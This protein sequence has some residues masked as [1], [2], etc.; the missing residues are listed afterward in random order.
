VTAPA[1]PAPAAGTPPR[2]RWPWVLLV[3]GVLAAAL[4]VAIWHAITDGGS[5]PLGIVIDGERV[6]DSVDL[7]SLAVHEQLLLALAATFVVLVVLLV[8]PV[9]LL[10]ALAG[11]LVAVALPLLVVLAALAILLSPLILLGWLL[12]RALRPSPSIE[13]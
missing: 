7:G 9:A 5:L 10:V 2:R 12:W 8:V 3:A 11:V 4:M 1:N 6:L 13:P